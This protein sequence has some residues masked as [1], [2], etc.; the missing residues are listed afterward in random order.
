M[1]IILVMFVVGKSLPE[2]GAAIDARI[3]TVPESRRRFVL[4]GRP[5]RRRRP[6]P[7]RAQ[8]LVPG[9]LVNSMIGA[10]VCLS[11][12]VITGYIAQISLLQM[13][14]AGVAAYMLAGLA[15]GWHIPF[16][17][18][19]ILA[20]LGSDGRWPLRRPACPARPRR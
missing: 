10:I 16:P 11:L 4:A 2:R 7:V 20:A 9:R 13:A 3:Q 19:P 14:L 1:I 6:R 8:R 17:F 5:L 12:V 18:A 15:N